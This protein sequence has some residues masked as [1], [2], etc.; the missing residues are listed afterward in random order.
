MPFDAYGDKVIVPVGPQNRPTTAQI[1][2]VCEYTE[3]DAPY[4]P[5]KMKWVTEI[6]KEETL[7]PVTTAQPPVTAIEPAPPKDTTTAED[8]ITPSIPSETYRYAQ[9]RFPDSDAL[10]F[11]RVSDDIL[12]GDEVIVPTGTMSEPKTARVMSVGDYTAKVVPLPPEKARWARKRSVFKPVS[13]AQSKVQVTNKANGSGKSLT[14]NDADTTRSSLRRSNRSLKV[15]SGI[16]AATVLILTV[17]LLSTQ[18]PASEEDRTIELS[19]PSQSVG[20]TVETPTPSQA[21]TTKETNP[22]PVQLDDTQTKGHIDQMLI[23]VND[24]YDDIIDYS[25]EMW[26]PESVSVSYEKIKEY[27]AAWSE[28]HVEAVELLEELDLFLPSDT[29]RSSW[30]NL[31]ELINNLVETAE[32][33]SDWDLNGDGD[34]TTEECSTVNN[35]SLQKAQEGKAAADGLAEAYSQ[36]T[37]NQPSNANSASSQSENSSSK[38]SSSYSSS[39]SRSSGS[40]RITGGGSPPSDPYNAKDYYNPED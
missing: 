33:L 17:L 38:S 7:P 19:S 15:L 23:K 8:P 9:L 20:E 25:S 39:A 18:K 24:Y 36:A 11:Y 10:H 2:L 31:R 34:Y 3:A 26:E 32:I 5:E 16:L 29:Y 6:A 22:D 40:S 30:Q 13:P 21:V 4:P 27:E 37:S 35:S 14:S 28:H 1:I 12:V